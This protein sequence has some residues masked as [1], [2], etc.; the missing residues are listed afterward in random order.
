WYMVETLGGN[1]KVPRLAGIESAA[2]PTGAALDSIVARAKAVRPSLQIREIRFTEDNGIVL[3]GQ[4]Q[5]WLVRDRAN[6]VAIDPGS[7]AITG[8]LDG[9]NLTV[10]QRVSE[11][12][13]PLH[14]GTFG[15]L[16]TKLIWFLFGAILTALSVTGTIICA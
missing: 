7:G 9:R 3:L 10:H 11:M 2:A 12:A 15:G 1:A 14:F 16:T 5:A 6:G 13:D 8:A 4:D